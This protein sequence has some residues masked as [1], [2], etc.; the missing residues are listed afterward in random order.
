MKSQTLVV[1]SS[2]R[3]YLGQMC[4][5]FGHRLA[6]EQSGDHATIAF[7]MGTCT[8]EAGADSLR[9]SAQAEDG[10]SLARLQEVAASHLV[11]FAFRE[12]LAITW[13]APGA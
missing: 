6:V 12:T 10:E 1:T 11:R 13:T 4:K 3:R 9:L 5:H 2:A 8:L 7:P